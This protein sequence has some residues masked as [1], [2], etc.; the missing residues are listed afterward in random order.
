MPRTDTVNEYLELEPEQAE[1][2]DRLKFA[3]QK[4]DEWKDKAED[5]TSEVLHVIGDRDG[6]TVGGALVVRRVH[7]DGR[8]IVDGSRLR[9]EMPEVYAAFTKITRPYDALAFVS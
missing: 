6:A 1:L 9:R 7:Y 4:R 3:R 5:L 8:E 2:V